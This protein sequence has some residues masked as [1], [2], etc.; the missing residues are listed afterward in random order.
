MRQERSQ[1]LGAEPYERSEARQ[2]YANGFKPK[3]LLTR[4]GPVELQ[5]PQVRE[6]VEFYPKALE[7]GLRSEQA[8]KLALAEM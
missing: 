1:A 2:G 4:M 7:K 6:G 3:T 8:L 5:I